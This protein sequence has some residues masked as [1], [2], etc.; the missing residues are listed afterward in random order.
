[1]TCRTISGRLAVAVTGVVL[2]AACGGGTDAD[3]GDAEV[4]R[5]AIYENGL[6]DVNEG[7]E[8]QDGGTL[9]V[10]EYTDIRSLDPAE[11][12][13]NGSTGGNAMAAIFDPLMRYD[14]E[15]DAVEPWLA[16]SLESNDD[17]TAWTLELRDGVQF[18]DGT[19]VD[20][21]A[22]AGSIERYT[23][24]FSLN[25][26]VMRTGLEDIEA[27][28]SSTVEFTLNEPW[29]RFSV[30]LAGGPGLI[31]APAAYEDPED[32]QPIGAGPFL[33]ENYAPDEELTVTANDDYWGEEPH[34]DGIRFTFL[35]SDDVA[36]D[37][38]R[39]GGVDVA[40]MRAPELVEEA[41]GE[42]IGGMVNTTSLSNNLWIN[43]REG[44]PGEDP[45]VRQAIYWA[46]DPEAFMERASEGAGIPHK[47]FFSPESSWSVTSEQ[48]EVDEEKA[49][50]LL[51][52]AKADGFDGTITYTARNDRASQAGA[53]AIQAMLE[54]VGFEV[55]LDLLPNVA[56]QVQSVYVDGDYDLAMVATSLQDDDVFGRA[57]NSLHSESDGN[58]T[59]YSSEEMDDLLG[60]LRQV[61]DP[62]DATEVV[63]RLEDLWSTDAPG[64]TLAS[65]GMFT[66]W[67][68]DV[69]G[70]VPTS[71]SNILFGEA[72]GE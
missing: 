15:T 30:V 4:D 25:A 62:T 49:R 36:L 64:I 21:E 24:S 51:E 72:W 14:A 56:D 50:E 44:H 57:S 71:E 48:P 16:E 26:Y 55:E 39:S 69:G 40:F 38:L 5:S 2:L 18:S 9:T 1:M 20:A 11:T 35:G 58:V 70:V 22:V 43:N 7:G 12:H 10:A 19:P 28:D 46:I 60:Q 34:L 23:E 27:V 33:F 52:E 29:P 45:R 42:G 59:E 32:F 3:S 66:A 47:T 6:A 17:G 8:P 54:A 63:E 31:L 65:G 41:R 37:T 13:V 68:D 61:S 67:N 53:V